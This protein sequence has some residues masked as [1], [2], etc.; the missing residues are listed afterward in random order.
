MGVSVNVS[1]RR[2]GFSAGTRE[3]P[4]AKTWADTCIIAH[5]ERSSARVLLAAN[6]DARVLRR[7]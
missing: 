5:H 2:C 3:E 6:A 7:S 1:L 4:T